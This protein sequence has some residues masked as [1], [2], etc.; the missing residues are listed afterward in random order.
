VRS[1]GPIIAPIATALAI[2]ASADNTHDIKDNTQGKR[3]WRR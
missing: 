2:P 3:I 1:S